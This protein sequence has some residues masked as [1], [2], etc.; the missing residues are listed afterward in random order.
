LLNNSIIPKIIAILGPTAVGKSKFA[1]ELAQKID[2][3]I[4]SADSIQVY[5]YFDTGT[6]KP[7]CTE[8]K[9]IPHHLVDIRYPDQDF[10]AGLYKEAATGV[11][12]ELRKKNKRIIIVGGSFLYIKVLLSGLIEN[13]P[14]N[15]DVRKAIEKVKSEKGTMYLYNELRRI[16]ADYAYKINRNDFIRIQRALEVYYLTGTKISELHEI[17]GFSGNEYNAFKLVLYSNPERLNEIIN[18]RV[19]TIMRKGLVEEVKYIRSLGYSKDA[20]PM[21]SIGYKEINQYLDSEIDIKEAVEL[22]KRNTRRF[23]K[24]QMTWIRGEDGLKWYDLESEK[25]KLMQD[26]L[27]FYG[28]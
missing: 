11:I 9:S 23:A 1:I 18:K 19:D 17:H 14:A 13:V 28:L 25:E 27:D 21:G 7:S 8:R 3:E 26:C 6:S 24:R 10:N 4:I 16:D 22:I 15:A 20:K 12:N 2:A 5:R